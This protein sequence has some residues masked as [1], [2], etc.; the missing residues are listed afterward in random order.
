MIAWRNG[1]PVRLSAVG[2]VIARGGERPRRRLA[3]RRH[4]RRSVLDIQR[5][6][7]ANIVQTVERD[8]GGAAPRCKRAMPAGIKLTI[9]TD[10]TE[11]IRA[12]VAD[13]QY[14]LM[15]SVV[16]VVG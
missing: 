9:V 2:S 14:T 4:A 16:L 12:S 3:Y 13:V 1:A 11:T 6:P 15:L 5:Q 8:E 7:G 10:R